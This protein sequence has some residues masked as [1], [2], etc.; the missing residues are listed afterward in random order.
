MLNWIKTFMPMAA[1]PTRTAISRAR[2]PA[3]ACRGLK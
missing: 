2:E 1:V 3:Y